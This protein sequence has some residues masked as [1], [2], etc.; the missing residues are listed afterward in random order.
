MP[1]DYLTGRAKRITDLVETVLAGTA[2]ETIAADAGIDQADLDLAVQTYR[3]GGH[4]ALQRT[5]ADAWFNA[6]VEPADWATAE[7]SF[8]VRIASRLAQLDSGQATWWF[9]R[10]HPCWRIRI[11]TAEHDTARAALDGLAAAGVITR[12]TPG[13]YEPEVAAFGGPDAMNIVHELFCADSR[14]VLGYVTL[15]APKLGRRELSLLLIHAIAHHAGLDWFETADVFD[16]IAQLRPAPPEADVARTAGLAAQTRSLLAVPAGAGAA[17]LASSG[18][19]DDLTASWLDSF[20]TAGQQVRDAAVSGLL[21]RGVRA[22]LA[23]VVI[24]HWNRL[25]LS[26]STQAILARAAATAMLP[27]S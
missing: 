6:M 10:K 18:I 14:G 16:R 9:V 5:Q 27:G 11:R 24:F 25:G 23:H 15:D 13:I 22:I 26:A 8:A 2:A 1:A 21:D 12:W 20:V 3:A 19:P 7:N 17:L 4:A